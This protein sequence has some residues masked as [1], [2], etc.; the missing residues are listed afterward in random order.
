MIFV[1]AQKVSGIAVKD[2]GEGPVRP[3]T[4]YFEPK[5]RPEGPKKIFGDRG[6]NQP[7]RPVSFGTLSTPLRLLFG[8]RTHQRHLD[9]QGRLYKHR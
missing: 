5:L 1:V 4:P 2:L 7:S 3:A 8:R 6:R 9:H